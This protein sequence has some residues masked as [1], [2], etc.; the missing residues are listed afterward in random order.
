MILFATKNGR[1]MTFF[2]ASM[3]ISLFQH[4]I[5]LFITSQVIFFRFNQKSV[6]QRI[7]NYPSQ[8]EKNFPI[9]FDAN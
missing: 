4:L 1:W 3:I 5:A 2:R 7:H 9:V 8:I 6:S